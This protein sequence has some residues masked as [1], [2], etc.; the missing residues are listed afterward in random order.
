MADVAT[1]AELESPLIEEPLFFV[2]PPPSPGPDPRLWPEEE[3]QAAFIAYLRKTSPKIIARAI[4]NEG[5]RGLREQRSMR[6]T[7]LLAGT[8]D[9][10]IFWDFRDATNENCP[11]SVA[12]IEF[13]GFTAKGRPGR[14]SQAQIDYG[15]GLHRRGHA[16][17]CCYTATAALDFLRELGAPVRGRVA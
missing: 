7:G 13:K 1:F 11:R 2:E 4:R 5:K 8:F 15:N 10:L 17:A 3:R 16:V 9:T 12:S 14:L 6:R